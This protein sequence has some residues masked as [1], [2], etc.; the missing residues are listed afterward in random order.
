MKATQQIIKISKRFRKYKNKKK[1][2][3]KKKIKKKNKKKLNKN[4]IKLHKNH[5]KQTVC[6]A[7]NQK[8][9]N[10]AFTEPKLILIINF[11]CFSLPLSLS[12][13]P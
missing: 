11:P 6:N 10:P 4:P 8:R 12:L 5:S 9:K 1:K 13:S 7:K 2:I 3:K